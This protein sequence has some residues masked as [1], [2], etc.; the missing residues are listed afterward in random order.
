MSNTKTAEQIES[1]EK[2]GKEDAA[3][4]REPLW[5]RVGESYVSAE[6]G[7]IGNSELGAA[8]VRA[9]CSERLAQRQSR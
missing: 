5:Y 2:L 9:Y 7:Q 8:Y 4:G 6:S 3:G 1:A